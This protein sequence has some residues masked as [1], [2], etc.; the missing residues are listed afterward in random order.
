MWPE[1]LHHYTGF[2]IGCLWFLLVGEII[3]ANIYNS[4][5]IG[6]FLYLLQH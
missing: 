1:T 3:L 6:I 4:S 2:I 5:T